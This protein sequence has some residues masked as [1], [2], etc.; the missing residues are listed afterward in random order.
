LQGIHLA[1][2][3]QDVEHA[4][5]IRPTGDT[6]DDLVARDKQAVFLDCV[7]DLLQEVWQ[8]LHHFV[9]A[10]ARSCSELNLDS[11]VV[12]RASLAHILVHDLH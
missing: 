10:V 1:Q 8:G 2:A 5:R 7:P 12:S 6:D 3:H 4:E 11:H 9:D